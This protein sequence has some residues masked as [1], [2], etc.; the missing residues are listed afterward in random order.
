M[1]EETEKV[2]Y[3]LEELINTWYYY[4]FSNIL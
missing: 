3:I 1:S 4:W 2:C